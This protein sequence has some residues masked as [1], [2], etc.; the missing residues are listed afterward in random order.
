MAGNASPASVPLAYTLDTAA[1]VSTVTV[2]ATTLSDA[3]VGLDR[4]TVLIRYNEQM[5]SA[6][7]RVSFVPNVAGD[8]LPATL[9][10]D[11][12]PLHSFWIK[13]DPSG[14]LYMATYTVADA[15]VYDPHVGVWIT[16]AQDLAG[17]VQMPRTALN[18]FSVNTISTPANVTSASSNLTLVSDLNVGE[19]QPR[20]YV[21]VEFDQTMAWWPKPT[22]GFSPDVSSTLVYD[23]ADSFWLNDPPTSFLAQFERPRRERDPAGRA[24]HGRGSPGPGHPA[25]PARYLGPETFNIDTVDPA[26]TRGHV[27][28]VEINIASVTDAATDPGSQPGFGSG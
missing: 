20:F 13:N 9:T 6:A 5:S 14:A 28:D 17:N 3:S 24:D 10:L 4:F 11:T 1:P 8:G 7:P 26:A 12:S 2:S 22:I 16:S 27:S 19:T 18:D 15:N 21:R 25:R 23:D